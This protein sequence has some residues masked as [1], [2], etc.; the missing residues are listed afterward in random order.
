[1]KLTYLFPLFLSLCPL[2][3]YAQQAALQSNRPIVFTKPVAL[4]WKSIP[5]ESINYTQTAVDGGAS[6]YAL[7]DQTS[8]TF[9]I[10]VV[11]PESIYSLSPE[12]RTTYGALNDLLI[13][14]GF[15]NL[16]FEQIQNTLS[17]NGINLDTSLNQN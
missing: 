6:I 2:N 12:V 15:G 8:L 13:L 4:N 1:M 10:R 3:I 7:P 5:F 11:L 9:N 17:L 14:G 16:T